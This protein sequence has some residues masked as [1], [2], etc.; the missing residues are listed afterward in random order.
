LKKHNKSNLQRVLG[1]LI[2][3]PWQVFAFQR[4][5]LQFCKWSSPAKKIALVKGRYTLD[6]FAHDIA[7]KR[8]CDKKTFFIQNMFF[9]CVLKIFFFGT[10]LNILK[11]HYNILK[12]KISFYQNVFLSFYLN[13]VCENV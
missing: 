8:Y 10:I 3:F 2:E 12:K 6:I 1:I 7:I 9:L 13:I 11:C 5:E 4:Y